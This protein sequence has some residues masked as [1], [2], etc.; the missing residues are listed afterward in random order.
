MAWLATHLQIERWREA[1][2][3]TWAVAKVGDA[4]NNWG[5]QA[6][7]ELREMFGLTKGQEKGRKPKIDVTKN[8]RTTTSEFG[9][10]SLKGGWEMPAASKILYSK[11]RSG[12]EI[13]TRLGC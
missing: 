6:R 13:T 8:D 12:T 9:V 1:L 7:D 10:N 2:L 5:A 3:W 11:L 4:D